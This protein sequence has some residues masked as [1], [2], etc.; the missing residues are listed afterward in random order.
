MKLLARRKFQ[1]KIGISFALLSCLIAVN[2]VVA[3]A[4]VYSIANMVERQ[5]EIVEIVREVEQTRLTVS[6]FINSLDRNL[7]EKV[8]D[9][10][11]STRQRILTT[12]PK[13]K[14]GKLSSLLSQLDDF[15]VRFQKYIIVAD[16]KEALE[17]RAMSLGGS[18][19][20]R[21]NAL[22]QDRSVNFN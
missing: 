13:H 4:V 9:Q 5:R 12:A 11:A 18:M 3:G 15:K 20:E 21:L 22:R 6:N 7:S 19:L 10:T 16:Q 14:N 2:T 1:E 8:F 17:S